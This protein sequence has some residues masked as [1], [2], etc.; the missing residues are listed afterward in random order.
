MENGKK[1]TKE[2]KSNFKKFKI[3]L[4]NITKN[5]WLYI[6]IKLLLSKSP[7]TLQTYKANKSNLHF[8]NILINAS[9]SFLYPQT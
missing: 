8:L 6:N 9:F 2:K 7:V 4:L 1:K 3:Y 5:K